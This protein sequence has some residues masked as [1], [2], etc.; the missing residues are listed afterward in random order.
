MALPRSQELR[1]R[2][3]SADPNCRSR[4]LPSKMW[5][6]RGRTWDWEGCATKAAH[7]APGRKKPGL[8]RKTVAIWQRF[9]KIYINWPGALTT[10]CC[11]AAWHIYSTYFP[12]LNQ[13]YKVCVIFILLACLLV[14]FLPFFIPHF[15]N[16]AFWRTRAHLEPPRGILARKI[17]INVYICFS[18]KVVITL[19]ASMSKHLG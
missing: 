10:F 1:F 3:Q 11:F 6:R 9:L 18:V 14:F 12:C 13:I 15:Y 8:K 4:Q 7:Q 19:V 17:I 2:S 16:L 5:S